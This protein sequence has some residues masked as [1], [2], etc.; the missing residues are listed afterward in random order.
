MA[1]VV[2]LAALRDEEQVRSGPLAGTQ[3]VTDCR[4]AAEPLAD[5]P[6]A[7]ALVLRAESAVFQDEYFADG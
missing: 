1:A 4:S 2:G 5:E 7:D 6:A 3:A